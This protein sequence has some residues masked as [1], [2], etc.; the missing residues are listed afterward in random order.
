[1]KEQ[2]FM[3]VLCDNNSEDGSFQQLLT[4]GKNELQEKCETWSYKQT[5]PRNKKLILI[6][7]G[8]N[9][10]FAGGCNVG[11]RYALLNTNAEY[12]W[13]LNN[14][15][16]TD[17]HALDRQTEAMKQRPHTGILGSTLIYFNEPNTM[18]A[19]GGYDFN[20]W[21][22]RVLPIAPSGSISDRPP[23]A[24]VERRLKY[25]SG[26]SMFVRRTF[27]EKIGL[28]ND[29]YFLYF[30]EIDWAV[31]SSARFQLGYCAQ[32]VIWH[33]EGKSIGSHATL[34]QRSLFSERYLAR[35]RVLFMKTYFPRRIAICLLWIAFVGM[36]RILHGQWRLAMTL[37]KGA[38]SGLTAPI[39]PLPDLH[40]WPKSMQNSV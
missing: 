16:V 25:V 39:K 21:T 13:L 6:Q 8:A 28:L 2:D 18:Q 19:P 35:N 3:I 26:A 7:T 37:W 20:F 27:L 36:T 38:L 12:V 1:M 9:L 23:E 17:A 14:D 11:L 10:G 29:Q 22:A 40:E 24:E 31:R 15:T 30:E 32:S 33:K 4:W 5:P 34:T